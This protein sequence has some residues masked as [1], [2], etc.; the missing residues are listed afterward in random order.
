VPVPAP[1]QPRADQKTVSERNHA[2]WND[3]S[4]EESRKTPDRV[5]VILWYV[6]DVCLCRNDLDDMLMHYDLLL[7]CACENVIV[8]RR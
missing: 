8:I 1:I 5:G 2:R 4:R 6:N 7:G 3:R